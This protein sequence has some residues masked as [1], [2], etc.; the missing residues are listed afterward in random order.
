ML[1]ERMHRLARL[2]AEHIA[3]AGVEARSRE[4]VVECRYGWTL[5]LV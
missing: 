1:L 3:V 5:V 2:L 4:V